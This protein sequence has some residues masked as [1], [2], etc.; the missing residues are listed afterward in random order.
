ME[1]RALLRDC[2]EQMGVSLGE[3]ETE[4]FMT[5]LSLLLEWNE[6]MNLTAITEP[7]EVVLKHFADCLSLVPCVEWRDGMRVIDVGTGAGFPGI[8]VK[9]AC[10]EIELTLL[11]SLQKRIGFLQEV[12]SQLGLRVSTMSIAVRRMADRTRS[13]V[14]GSICAFHAQLQIF[15]FW[16]NIACLLLRSAAGLRH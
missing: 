8:P 11:D 13:T 7:R 16:R 5:Y 6:K 9:I 1:N 12:G 15:L 3:K 10:P 4:Q 14:K 2:C